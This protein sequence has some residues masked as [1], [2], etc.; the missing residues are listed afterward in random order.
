MSKYKVKFSIIF[1]FLEYNTFL[2]LCK[3]KYLFYFVY[4]KYFYIFAPLIIN[5]GCMTEK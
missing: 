5:S 1:I 4:I 3:N 2:Y